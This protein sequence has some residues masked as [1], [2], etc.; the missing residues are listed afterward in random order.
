M[1]NKTLMSDVSNYERVLP[2]I[3]QK[4]NLKRVLEKTLLNEDHYN[5]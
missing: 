4:I 1:I 2:G 5:I 3:D